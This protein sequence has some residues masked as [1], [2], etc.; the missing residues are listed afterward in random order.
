ME[1]ALLCY[2][3]QL[4]LQEALK[5]LSDVDHMFLGGAGEDEDVIMVDKNKL[6]QHV[7][8]NVN[9]QT[10]KAGALVRSKGMNRYS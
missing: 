5:N 6:V 2:Y 4:V 8:E 10:H 3:K 7:A 9:H 1:L